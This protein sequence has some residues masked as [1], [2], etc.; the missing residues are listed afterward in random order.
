MRALLR[1]TLTG[2]YYRSLGKWTSNPELAC[3]FG[4]VALAMGV[5]RQTN[6]PNLELSLSF[7]NPREAAS[8]SLNDLFRRH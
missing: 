7:D 1:H 6:S 3:D 2:Q 5:A 8:F 4:A